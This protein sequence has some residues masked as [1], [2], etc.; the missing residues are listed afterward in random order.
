MSLSPY[1]PPH[2]EPKFDYGDYVQVLSSPLIWCI[3]GAHWSELGWWYNVR[4][5]DPTQWHKTWAQRT[6][7]S[8]NEE[9]LAPANAMMVLAMESRG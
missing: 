4:L 1:T 3:L 9:D 7:A 2:P 5:F 8:Y 6:R